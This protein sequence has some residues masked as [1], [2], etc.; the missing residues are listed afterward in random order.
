MFF[1]KTG[2]GTAGQN[3]RDEEEGRSMPKL[4]VVMFA[5]LTLM[6]SFLG[7]AMAVYVLNGQEAFA[8]S[9]NPNTPVFHSVTARELRIVDGEGR[10]RATLDASNDDLD[11]VRFALVAKGGALLATVEANSE[12]ATLRLSHHAPRS[13]I[14]LDPNTDHGPSIK[15]EVLRG[16]GEIWSAP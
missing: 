1:K 3:D 10:L 15:M 4:R 13:F 7:R 12:Y 16:R 5:I 9:S 2:I 8:Q 11:R 6:S 14:M